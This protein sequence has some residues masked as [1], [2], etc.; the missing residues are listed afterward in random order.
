M[1]TTVEK[2]L[3]VLEALAASQDPVPLSQL[4]RDMG[5]SKSTA[6]RLL[7]T[8][9]RTGYAR[10]ESS[11]GRYALST[12]M[13]ELGGSVVRDLEIRTIGHP[14]LEDVAAETTEATILALLHGNEALVID[15]VT[16][17]HALQIFSSV[18]SRVGLCHSA[19]GKALLA[20]MPP[21]RLKQIART[22]NPPTPSGLQTW[23][24][25]E[26]HLL[27]I[28]KHGYALS[29]DEWHV[30]VAGI[31]APV[32]NANG[33]V[34]GAFGITWPTLRVSET[35]FESLG[36]TCRAAAERISYALGYRQNH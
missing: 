33:D 16:S 20:Y 28:R 8:L 12:K 3:K 32:C 7:D 23:Q 15:T 10:Q 24:E 34:I 36:N 5:L 9:C 19:I 14:V 4:S 35:A 1:S 18:G 27:E 11:T 26:T 30:G 13:W 29:V 2:A 17:H 6:F 21:E 25:L 22:F 31:A